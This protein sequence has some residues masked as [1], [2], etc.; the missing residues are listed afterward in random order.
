MKTRTAAF[1]LAWANTRVRRALYYATMT[2]RYWN[3]SAF[4]LEAAPITIPRREI[5]K[6]TGLSSKFDLPLQNK[7]LP[8][9]VS[10]TLLD[11]KYKWLP[12][13][14]AG[15]WRKDS[16]ATL[17]G[18]DPV[19]SEVTIY[20]GLKLADDS[21][22]YLAQFTGI[23][24]DDPSFDSVS[25]LVTFQ[26]LE[27]AS[28]KLEAA[29]AQNVCVTGT[30]HA[31]SPTTGDSVIATFSAVLQS[32]WEITNVT[33]NAIVRTQG[34]DYKLDDLND[35]EV[36][37]NIVF[38]AASIPG[39]FAIT[40]DY[41]Q[42]YRDKSISE[43]VGLLCDEA[44]ISSGE[45][46]IE[47]P[48]FTGVDQSSA[49]GSGAD[50]VGGSGT[51][52]DATSLSGT[53]RRKWFRVDNFADGDITADPAWTTLAGTPT[54][55]ANALVADAVAGGTDFVSVA[56]AIVEGTWEWTA[57][58]AIQV[59]A[60]GHVY[61]A[62]DIAHNQICEIEY[63][64][65]G[66]N[67]S[68]ITPGGSVSLGLTPAGSHVWRVTRS[69]AGV[70]NVYLDTV[71]VATLTDTTTIDG[72]NM[73]VKVE[74]LA[75]AG[76]STLTIDDIWVSNEVDAV[77]AAT[78]TDLI[79]T[80]AFIDLLAAPASWLPMQIS[81][82]LNGGTMTIKTR[83]CTTSG[84]AY[85]AAVALDGTNT[86]T[87]ALKQ[88][89]KVVVETTIATAAL[90]GPEL[91]GVVINWRGSS[92]FIH[93]ADF[94]GQTCLQAVQ[95]LA[96]IGGME[97]GPNGDGS[98]Y[99]RNK[100][101]MG[102]ADLTIS[103]KNAIVAVSKFSTGYKD[104]KPISIVR[105]GKSGT[106]GYYYAEYG[107]AQSGE[108]S[109]TT[110]ERFG[111]KTIELELNRFIFANNANVAMAIAQKNYEQNYLPK[112]KLTIKTRIIPHL[113]CSDKL[114]ISFHDSPLVEK[115]IFGDPFQRYPVTG[116]NSKTLARDIAMKVVGHAPDLMS[117]QSTIDLE[118]ILE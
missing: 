106:D 86:P 82:V 35:A 115:A 90:I 84:G 12:S 58:A 38:E 11:K 102:A 76:T 17:L 45:R 53:L 109:P 98:F 114:A 31:T 13:N 55:V 63:R 110:A 111:D 29:R 118:E 85:D 10:L 51:N 3:G 4:V 95:E 62:F 94:T 75:S 91:D 23:V 22:E 74:G 61:F 40:F 34:T 83:T 81:S 48:I 113:N 14:T 57:T 60:K 112:R 68:L 66:T 64:D 79:W 33:W 67:A 27:K 70:Y 25:G 30:A 93:S 44:G 21:M 9:Q 36:A 2:R 104:V 20:Y 101:V 73:A 24:Q 54:V 65:G 117:S 92:L 78:A 89:L 52:Y 28:A 6:I 32:I 39:A 47:E 16:V 59:G 97:F 108:A 72:G 87:S 69:A 105:Y 116:A 41:R 15:K 80:S 100:P 96:K 56:S 77:G 43:L 26:L 7:I 49:L 8:A 46:T 1:D 99:F 37:P 19:G 42:W 103:Q 107:A 50:F 71:F 5:D 18:Y 88:F